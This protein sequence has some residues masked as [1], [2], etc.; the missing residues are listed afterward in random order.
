MLISEPQVYEYLGMTEKQFK[1]FRKTYG[2]KH[3]ARAYGHRLYSK[4]DLDDAIWQMVWNLPLSR[5]AKIRKYKKTPAYLVGEK[6]FLS[7][8]VVLAIQKSQTCA[9]LEKLY[10][11]HMKRVNNRRG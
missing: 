9:K 1:S 11:N 3:Q 10:D 4:F 6:E 5:I 2:I 8:R 7:F